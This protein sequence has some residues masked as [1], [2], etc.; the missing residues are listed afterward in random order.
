MER[1]K[2]EKVDAVYNFVLNDGHVVYIG[3]IECVTLGH[4]KKGEV[5]EHAYWGTELVI[6]DLKNMD[7]GFE[8]GYVEIQNPVLK[9]DIKTGVVKQLIE[10][11]N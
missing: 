10:A 1:I 5:V 6:N 8:K 9:R 7:L 3:G 2:T 4:G 11:K